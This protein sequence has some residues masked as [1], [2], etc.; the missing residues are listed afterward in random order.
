M[1]K[2]IKKPTLKQLVEGLVIIAIFLSMLIMGVAA[3][4][5]EYSYKQYETNNLNYV[6]G[7]VT[8]IVEQQLTVSGAD[9]EYFTG[10]QKLKVQIN[11]GEFKGETVEIDNYITAQ[12]NV[13]VAKGSKVIVCADVPS[14]AS[15]YFTLYNYDRDAGIWILMAIFLL[16]VV[17]VGEKKGFMSCIGLAFT[18]C[19][20]I[21]WLLPSLYNGGNAVL[22]STV[23]VIL[24]TA[25]SCFCIGGLSKKTA[26]NIIST[27]IGCLSAGIIYKLFSLALNVSG[28]SMGETESLVLISQS[29][30][31]SLSGVLFAGILISSLGAVMDVGVS[32]GASLYEIKELNPEISAKEL[33]RSGMN[34]GKDMI[35]TM[36]NTLILAFSGGAIATLVILVSYGV[37]YNQLFSSNYIALEVA[38]GLAGSAAVVLT[39]P[40]SAAI[41]AF[42]YT[43]IFSKKI[44]EEDQ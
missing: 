44:K 35:G 27:T 14:N 20:I 22:M 40:I 28:V 25:V 10:F 26:L 6:R 37:Q 24:S 39:V 38:K 2:T 12:H 5:N 43:K 34:I 15:P 42:G 18:M 1:K 29:T 9:G 8:E 4:N 36:T 16:L 19:S 3:Y 13:V 7:T 21:F 17:I 23:V 31:L 41:C 11:E 33:F 32:I 30:G